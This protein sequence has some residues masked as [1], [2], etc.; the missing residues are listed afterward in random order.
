M[1][2]NTSEQRFAE[3]LA[4]AKQYKPKAELELI[5]QSIIDDDPYFG[6]AYGALS[7]L[8]YSDDLFIEGLE[9]VQK[10]KQVFKSAFEKSTLPAKSLVP[11]YVMVLVELAFGQ[12]HLGQ[13]DEALQTLKETEGFIRN[14]WVNDIPATIIRLY[15]YKAVAT[16]C[17]LITNPTRRNRKKIDQAIEHD[18]GLSQHLAKCYDCQSDFVREMSILLEN[19]AM[20]PEAHTFFM[21][22]K[23]LF[24]LVLES[25]PI[26]PS[27]KD[28]SHLTRPRKKPKK[29]Q[30]TEPPSSRKWIVRPTP[31]RRNRV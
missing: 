22:L 30:K 17:A 14:N 11:G 25:S 15:L 27:A 9:I 24:G 7:H 31:N 12:M 21:P 23:A 2:K 13:F 8:F 20:P 4:L 5:L 10:G 29:L 6:K 26:D 1:R 3:V 28:N 16:I 18:L 19:K